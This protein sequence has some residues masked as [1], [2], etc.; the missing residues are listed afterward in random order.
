MISVSDGINVF[1]SAGDIL[2]SFPL[3]SGGTSSC[4]PLVIDIDEDNDLELIY[5]HSSGLSVFDI[6]TAGNILD[7]NIYRGNFHRTGTTNSS[8]GI[9]LGDVNIDHQR[10]FE[11]VLTATRPIRDEKVHTLI[12]FETPSGTE[13]RAATDPRHFIPN[14]FNMKRLL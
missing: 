10:T 13:W 3:Q 5:G 7:W 14:M 4:S 12:S 1:S 8:Y 11:A 2:Y 6:K 9:I